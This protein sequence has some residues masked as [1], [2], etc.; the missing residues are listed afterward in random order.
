[1]ARSSAEFKPHIFHCVGPSPECVM[2]FDVGA[3]VFV[4]RS[5][6]ELRTMAK[7]WLNEL[8]I[9]LLSLLYCKALTRPLG[10]DFK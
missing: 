10:F 1:M 6:V 2:Q 7:T 8:R 5:L 3:E 9:R 4:S